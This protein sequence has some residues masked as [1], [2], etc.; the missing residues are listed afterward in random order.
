MSGYDYDVIVVGAESPGEHCAGELADGGLKVAVVEREL[1]GASARSGPV[2]RPRR[3]CVRVRR[4]TR[5]GRPWASRLCPH[6]ATAKITC[7]SSATAAPDRL[8][9][10]PCRRR[11]E[12]DLPHPAGGRVTSRGAARS[13][14]AAAMSGGTGTFEPWKPWNGRNDPSAASS[15]SSDLS[16]GGLMR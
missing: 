11:R 4:L 9:Q 2:S 10:L 1:A 6:G 16:R 8:R 13:D 12:G 3:C 14:S 5:P 7:W 15:S